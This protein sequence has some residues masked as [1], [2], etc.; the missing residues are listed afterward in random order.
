[1]LDGVHVFNGKTYTFPQTSSKRYWTMTF[2]NPAYMEK[3][4]YD[5]ESERLT[6][7][8][9]RE[10]ARKVTEQGQ[11]EY[12]GVIIGGKSPARLTV[13]VQNLARMAGASAGGSLGFN[14]IDWRTGEFQYTSDQYLGAIE[15]LLALQQD[16]S[17]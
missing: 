2:Y 6:W 17:I 15:L 13:F 5:L 16:G 11:G 8:Q 1:F 12:Y 14:D 3:A 7:D 9:Y 10:A 4:G